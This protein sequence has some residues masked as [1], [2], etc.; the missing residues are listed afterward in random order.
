MSKAK[1]KE[2]AMSQIKAAPPKKPVGMQ[3]MSPTLY[4]Q[5]RKAVRQTRAR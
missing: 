2:Q 3:A 4:A 5:I 1:K